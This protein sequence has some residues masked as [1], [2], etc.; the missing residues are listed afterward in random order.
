MAATRLQTIDREMAP[1]AIKSGATTALTAVTLSTALQSMGDFD[2]GN[3]PNVS[4]KLAWTTGAAVTLTVAPWVSQD[5]VTYTPAPD[6]GTPSAGAS[7]VTPVTNTIASATWDVA[8]QGGGAGVA[9]VPIYWQLAGWRF[10]RVYVKSSA[11][12]GSVTGTI[13]AGTGS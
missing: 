4:L 10:V 3:N 12:A 5:D 9:T 13:C 8:A 2:L 6:F 1:R 11:A 7:V